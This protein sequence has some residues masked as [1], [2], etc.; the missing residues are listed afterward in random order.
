LS[1][2][3][4]QDKALQVGAGAAGGAVVAPLADKLATSAAR[5]I[6]SKMGKNY[7]LPPEGMEAEIRASFAR[8]DIDVS[9]IPKGVMS[10]LT[11][12][13]KQAMASGKQVD[14][15]A[16]L[17]KMDFDKVG[18]QPTTGQLTRNP[19]QYSRELNLRGI[20]GVGEPLADR[21]S[22]QQAQLGARMRNGATG[23]DEYTAGQK[24][25]ELAKGKGAAMD[26][27]IRAS[28]KAFRDS[29][30][31]DLEVPITGLASDYAN[32]LRDFG[33]TIP[34]AV[35]RQF[36]ELGLLTGKQTKLMTI[37]D[38]ER[39]IKVI[40]KNYN[41]ADKAQSKALDELRSHLQNAVINTTEDGA[42]MEAATLGNMARSSFAN[43]AKLV[44]S[45]PAF[46]A[47]LNDAEPD[48]FVRKFVL[49]GKVR[50]INEFSKLVGPEG[51]KTMS[52]QMLAYLEKKAF[53]TNAAGDGAASQ[54]ALNRELDKI[55]RNKLTALLG[56]EKTDE[57]YTLGR[58]AAYIQ[59]RPAG[60]A[61]NESN[62]GAE[63]ANLLNKVGGTVKGAPYINDWVV[64]PMGAFRD[65]NAI[66]AA[67]SA[68]LP[69]E[70]A[71]LDAKTVNALT[72][73]VGASAVGSGTAL[74]FSAR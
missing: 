62:T 6:K 18:I 8:D 34:G 70:P 55:G 25:V 39:L 73:L 40:N 12:E 15:A 13:V 2:D 37:D 54:A 29:T 14:A 60:S 9:Q 33:E 58:V 47:A 53:G 27:D 20:Q 35:R 38:A 3:Y 57:L 49:N 71:K 44:D 50:E 52:Q 59:Q 4:W 11:E 61:V 67:L 74:G 48:D 68:Q 65:R 63:V 5:F 7:V 56:P 72:R 1:D 16:M 28:Y 30:G 64:K 26:A 51:Q 31:K 43:K 22:L 19:A 46:K 17:R 42:A 23:P 66:K 41:P 10:K 24:L 36:E 69:N 32:T 21:F 45:V